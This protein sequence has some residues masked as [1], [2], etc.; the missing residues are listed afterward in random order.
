MNGPNERTDFSET[1]PHLSVWPEPK[2][3]FDATGVAVAFWA[4]VN[5]VWVLPIPQLSV[6]SLAGH[7]LYGA[8]LGAVYGLLGR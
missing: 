1:V 5:T 3:R 8:V 7:V 6:G 2:P 4:L